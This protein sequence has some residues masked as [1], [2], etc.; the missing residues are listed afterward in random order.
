VVEARYDA[1]ADFYEAGWAE[2]CDDPATRA[3]LDLVGDVA[4]RRVLDLAC[5]HGRVSRHLAGRG[6]EVTGVDLS[7]ALIAK[8]QAAERARP[9]G[10]R[11]LQADAAR[12]GLLAGDRFDAVVCCFGLSDIDDLDGAVASVARL[13]DPGGLFAFSIL[14]PC[15]PGGQDTSGAWPPSGSYYQEGW[16]RADATLSALRRRVGANHRMLSTYLN[17]LRRHDLWLDA[18]DEPT[19]PQEW[20]DQKRDAAR[21]PVFL[22]VRCRKRL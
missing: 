11:Y 12:Q 8:A 18:C 5:G 7:G 3:L 22:T 13:L 14:H 6:A 16:W 21:M 9:R 15:F 2:G 1:V 17:T 20:I 19:P 10:I 4:G